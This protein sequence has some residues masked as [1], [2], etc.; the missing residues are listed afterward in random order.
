MQKN[1]VRTVDPLGR[2]VLPKKFRNE[3][4]WKDGT[5]LSVSRD[6]NKLILQKENGS[7]FLK[8]T[9]RTGQGKRPVL[10]GKARRRFKDR[11]H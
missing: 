9:N 5:K 3:M 6:R 4:C 11:I 2:V 1:F 7:C 10:L 8:G